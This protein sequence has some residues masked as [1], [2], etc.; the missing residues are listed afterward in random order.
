MKYLK[1]LALVLLCSLPFAA[2]AIAAEYGTHEDA[3]AM[4]KKAVAYLKE[5]GKEKAYAE[6]NSQKGQFKDRDLYIFVMDMNGVELANG[7][8]AKLVGKNLID[9]KDA[10]GKA[11]VK[12]F[13]D[14]ARTKGSGWVDYAWPNPVKG[15]VEKKSTYV[16]KAGDI[17]IGC[18]IYQK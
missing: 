13:I 11:M 6:F 7:S 17:L 10:G 8:N 16:E 14:V 5:N 12:E 2:P 1:K 4:V 15:T 18:G 3:T 9:L